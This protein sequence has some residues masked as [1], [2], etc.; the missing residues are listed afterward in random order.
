MNMPK[1]PIEIEKEIKIENKK[2]NVNQIVNV[3]VKE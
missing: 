2:V 1:M 3:I